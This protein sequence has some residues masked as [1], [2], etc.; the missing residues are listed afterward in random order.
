MQIRQNDIV[1]FNT[2]TL[3][4]SVITA[5]KYKNLHNKHIKHDPVQ[6]K[7]TELPDILRGLHWKVLSTTNVHI[8]GYI[9]ISKPCME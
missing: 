5:H 8:I 2:S 1:I 9:A 4:C 6:K 7:T 3:L